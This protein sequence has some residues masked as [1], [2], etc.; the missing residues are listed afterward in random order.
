VRITTGVIQ[1]RAGAG[2]NP[3]VHLLTTPRSF[4]ASFDVTVREPGN[5][6]P[7][8]AQ[9]W[10]PRNFSA[11]AVTF[12]AAP[13]YRIDALVTENR[14]QVVSSRSLGTYA[15]G[16]TYHIEMVRD[17]HD[18]I[19]V[20]AGEAGKRVSARASFGPDDAPHVF[21]AY[22]PALTVLSRSG[23]QPASVRISDYQLRLPH[24]RFLTARVDDAVILPLALGFI[25]AS[26][27]LHAP[28]AL[29]GIRRIHLGAIAAAAGAARRDAPLV[30]RARWPW[31]VGA[32]CAAAFTASILPL[33]SHLFDMASQTTWT[34]LAVNHGLSGLYYQSQTIPLARVWNGTPFH[35]AVYPYG[36]T[37]SYYF[38]ALGQ[39]YQWL[40]GDVSPDSRG[41]E[42]AIKTANLLVACADAWIIFLLARGY[43]RTKL[44]WIAPAAF[45]LNPAVFFDLAVWGETESVALFFLLASLLASQRDAPRLAWAL[46]ALSFLGKQTVVVPSVLVALYYLRLFPVRDTLAGIS[47]AAPVV[48]VA[49]LPFLASGYPPS[50]AIDPVLGAFNVFGGS[51]TE[52]PFKVVS[53]DSF[54]VWPL[55]TLLAHDQHGLGR[56]LYPDTATVAGA[57]YQQIGIFAFGAVFVVAAAWLTLSSDA[58]RRPAAVPLVL[59]VVMA[60]MLILPTRSIARYLIFPLVFAIIAASAAPRTKSM[61]FVMAAFTCTSLLGMYGSVASGLESSP[62]SAPRLAPANNALSALALDMF[63]SDIVMTLASLLNVGALLA[64]CAELWLPGPTSA[65]S[66]EPGAQ[67]APFPASLREQTQ[68]IQEPGRTS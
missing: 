20:S 29:R 28:I 14:G 48:L 15:V 49:L 68:H 7:F 24:E 55:V 41:L 57:S 42:V 22:R 8:Q 65:E 4:E 34:Y 64:L 44:A 56:L 21:E 31:A 39:V 45:L 33:G 6:H 36:V 59:A 23:L 10:N 3:A 30:V 32:L 40:G 46:L 52:E 66:P 50:T 37:M 51:E 1:L 47:V 35:E 2:V 62:M 67:R 63:R 11:I 12:G 25:A 17:G 19:S 61:W 54:S 9:I 38:L 16:R 27:A 58:R 5:G 43:G 18:R 60:A 53:Y 26:I 13:D